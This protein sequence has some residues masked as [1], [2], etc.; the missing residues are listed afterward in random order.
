M[1]TAFTNLGD[2]VGIQFPKSLLQNM[3]FS[4]D[5]EVEI[6]IADKNIV[7]K[8]VEERRHLTTKERIS[9]FGESEVPVPLS[10][11]DWGKPQ[12]REIW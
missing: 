8:R 7:I 6:L 12:G 2:N 5:D 11:T 9:S 4:E 10:E 3:P 1:I